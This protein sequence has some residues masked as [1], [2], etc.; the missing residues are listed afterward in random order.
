VILYSPLAS[1]PSQMRSFTFIKAVSQKRKKKVGEEMGQARKVGIQRSTARGGI[2]NRTWLLSP[3]THSNCG[4]WSKTC[5]RSSQSKLPHSLVTPT[6][7]KE[8]LQWS[9]TG[10]GESFI[11]ECVDAPKCVDDGSATG[12]IEKALTRCGRLSEEEK[13]EEK[14]EDKEEKEEDIKFV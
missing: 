13:E 14:K 2:L 11:S 12:H 1:H 3:L 6:L 9:V 4:Y 8:L 7:T 5:T 10:E